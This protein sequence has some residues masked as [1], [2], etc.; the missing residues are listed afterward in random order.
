MKPIKPNEVNFEHPVKGPLFERAVLYINE[1][2]STKRWHHQIIEVKDYNA[3]ILSPYEYYN[4]VMDMVV[5]DFKK[6]GWDCYWKNAYDA[7]GPHHCFYVHKKHF[8]S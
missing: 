7:R 5:E 3:I 8:T 4:S 1:A 2:I 6:A